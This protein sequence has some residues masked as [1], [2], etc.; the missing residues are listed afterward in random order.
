MRRA[1]RRTA[2]RTVRR[3]SRRRRRRRRRR[4]ILLTGGMIALGNRKMR[5]ED[6][7]RIEE[8]T[9]E[10]AENLTDEELDQAMYDLGI[11]GQEL[12]EQDQAYIDQQGGEESAEPV[13]STAPAGEPD[14]INEL[15]R[16][17][18]LRDQGIISDEEF[19]TKKK[20]LL[21]L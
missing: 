13:T 6:V 18:H 4:I 12:D 7:D 2:R 5:Q 11:E 8:H 16:L 1:G 21:G 3:R 9:G 14:Y 17:A 20:Q 10:S 15:E 19:E